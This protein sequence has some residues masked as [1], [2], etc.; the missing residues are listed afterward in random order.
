[1]R[2]FFEHA[3]AL[4]FS[5]EMPQRKLDRD[6]FITQG[7]C[8]IAYQQK[9]VPSKK[10]N[11]KDFI[12]Y[13]YCHSAQ[14][15]LLSLQ[16]DDESIVYDSGYVHEYGGNTYTESKPVVLTAAYALKLISDYC[17]SVNKSD[18]Y[19]SWRIDIPTLRRCN[20]DDILRLSEAHDKKFRMA[21][22]VACMQLA[23][24][25]LAD[26]RIYD[27]KLAKLFHIPRQTFVN[28]QYRVLIGLDWRLHRTNE[29][30]L[31]F[32]EHQ[33]LPPHVSQCIGE[34][35]DATQDPSESPSSPESR[36]T[37][38]IL[39]SESME[40]TGSTLRFTKESSA[41][42]EEVAQDEKKN[43]SKYQYE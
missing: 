30:L 6:F 39:S 32:C 38:L 43:I 19:P 7:I 28:L 26:S 4:L 24:K 35:E 13:E 33:A 34:F 29:Q 27:A 37:E 36:T 9:F 42:S 15:Y 11:N 10:S 3:F 14:G 40:S 21:L 2:W 5:E 23:S 22:I 8:Y 1:M 41:I 18:W 25:M 20:Q 17:T 16:E 12:A 31:S